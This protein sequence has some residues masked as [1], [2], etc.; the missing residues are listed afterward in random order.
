MGVFKFVIA[1]GN[2]SYQIERDQSDC[3]MLIGLRIGDTF[4]GDI[5][6]LEGYELKITG[7]ADKDGFPMRP[8]LEGSVKKRLLLTKSIGFRGKKRRKK[9]LVKIKGLR[10]RKTVRGNTISKDTVQINCKVIKRGS[11]PLDELLGKKEE[12][13]ENEN[14]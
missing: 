4:S 2:K 1:N 14:K 7:G 11:K 10:R 3:E 8:D 9:E 12:Q 13:K 6:G 5:I